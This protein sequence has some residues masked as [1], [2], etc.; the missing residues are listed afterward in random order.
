[1]AGRR[2]GVCI[3]V[4]RGERKGPRLEAVH[5]CSGQWDA[6]LGDLLHRTL[7]MAGRTC[8]DCRSRRLQEAKPQL[9]VFGVR[10]ECEAHRVLPRQFAAFVPV[11]C[12]SSAA[13]RDFSRVIVSL[14]RSN[15][16]G[17]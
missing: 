3:T 15:T 1:M 8:G 14:P 11:R 13:M 4:N 10:M 9:V 17:E 6:W 12:R 2:E 7:R 5:H 16:D